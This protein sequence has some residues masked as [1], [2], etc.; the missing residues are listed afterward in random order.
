MAKAL[1]G[2][3]I[4]DMGQII[5][6]PYCTMLLADLGAEVIKVEDRDIAEFI[7]NV[8]PRR[9]RNGELEVMPTWYLY[10]N[11]NK[12][13]MTLNLQAPK[14]REIFLELSQHA[15]VIV[16]NFSVGVVKRLGVDYEAV[17][18]V[19]PRIVYASV[20]AFGQTGPLAL[21]R[22]YDMLAQ[23]RSGLMDLTG[24]ANGPPTKAGN[25]IADYFAGFHCAIAILAALRHR[26]ATG[27]GQYIDIA[28]LD[29]LVTALDSAPEIYTMTGQVVHRMGNRH[30][31]TAGYGA[32]EASDGVIAIGLVSPPIWERFCALI[33]QPALIEDPRFAEYME[34]VQHADE[35]DAIIQ[36]WLQDKTKEEAVRLLTANGVPAAPIN[37]ISEMINDPQVQARNMHLEIEHPDYG[38]IVITNSALKMSE[39]PGT[40][41][42]PAPRVGQ[43]NAEL[44]CELLGYSEAEVEQLRADGIM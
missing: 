22:G 11:R 25:S 10:A 8:G 1:Q 42:T 39:T 43:H 20:S 7:L 19:N 27:A 14:G 31:L 40:I 2:I 5:A 26:D 12:K 17:R 6:L 24:F 29:S 41:E 34:R 37:T 18:Q 16:E 3:R 13:H 28:L 23:A 44:L 30:L 33:G 36:A 38:P 32:Y 15:D 4:L 9:E 21:H 35:L